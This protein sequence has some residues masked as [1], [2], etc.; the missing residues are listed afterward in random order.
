MCIS[1][2]HEDEKNM[3]GSIA[4]KEKES[5]EEKKML[6]EANHIGTILHPK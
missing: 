3:P 6:R 5:E 1:K 4:E 2:T